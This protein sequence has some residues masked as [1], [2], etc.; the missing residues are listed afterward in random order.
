MMAICSSQVLLSSVRHGTRH[1]RLPSFPRRV[2]ALPARYYVASLKYFG[3]GASVS[4]LAESA[5]SDTATVIAIRAVD[6]FALGMIPMLHA[7][8]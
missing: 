2:L 5:A 4:R 7:A 6:Y 8:P 3:K 1:I